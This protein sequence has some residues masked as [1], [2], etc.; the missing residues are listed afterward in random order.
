MYVSY[1]ISDQNLIKGFLTLN[2]NKMKN[3]FIVNKY[4]I[5]EEEIESN[6]FSKDS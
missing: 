5:F 6:I 2:V 1:K 3:Y 4:S